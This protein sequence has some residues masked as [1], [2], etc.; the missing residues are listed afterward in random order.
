MGLYY[1][2]TG[3]LIRGG[4]YSRIYGI[5]IK[6]SSE[7]SH[8][9]ANGKTVGIYFSSNPPFFIYYTGPLTYLQIYS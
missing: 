8:C 4:A 9:V 5:T 2:S 6:M 3:A 1:D 7:N